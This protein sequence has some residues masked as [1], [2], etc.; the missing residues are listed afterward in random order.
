M[1]QGKERGGGLVTGTAFEDRIKLKLD[2][3][4]LLRFRRRCRFLRRRFFPV[5]NLPF[6]AAFDLLSPR[7]ILRFCRRRAFRRLVLR[8]R[9]IGCGCGC[10]GR[11]CGDDG[12]AYRSRNRSVTR[13]RL[14]RFF[15]IPGV[16]PCHRFVVELLVGRSG[17]ALFFSGVS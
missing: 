9:A 3:F 17:I 1:G 6:I 11:R 12:C 15:L 13:S 16:H 14:G 4:L 7:F 2:I 8:C 5:Q 10:A